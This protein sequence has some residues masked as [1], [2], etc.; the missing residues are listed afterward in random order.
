MRSFVTSLTLYLCLFA[1]V[2]VSY[3]Q[4]QPV[5]SEFESKVSAIYTTNYPCVVRIATSQSED[6]NVQG[7]NRFGTGFIIN[8]GG[9]V[10]TLADL[11]CDTVNT[12]VIMPDDWQYHARIVAIDRK[13]NIA[14]LKIPAEGLPVVNFGS[15]ETLNPGQLVISITN[16]YGLTNSLAVGFVSGLHRSGFRTG[17]IENFI[18]TTIPLNPGDSGSPLFN[19][20]GEVIGIMTAVL[21]DDA[22]NPDNPDQMFQPS[23][24]SFAIPSDII[25]NNIS[26]MIQHGK[27]KHSW[28]G[29]EVQ[30][31]MTEDFLKYGITEKDMH[32]GILVTHVFPESPAHKGGILTGDMILAV[33]EKP[34]DCVSDLQMIILQTTLDS[35]IKVTVLRDNQKLV[36][37]LRTE[38]MPETILQE[39]H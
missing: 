12:L 16:P 30:N 11:V 37:S 39:N 36:L 18:Q 24:I 8:E 21:V 23:D 15:A 38:E 2:E 10:L 6:P 26:S 5:L 19:C 25:K 27:I 29:L 35:D 17:Q 32:H 33:D 9:Y 22:A 7:C 20:K 1:V 4:S 14:I 13:L 28:I 3:A 34:I 31:L